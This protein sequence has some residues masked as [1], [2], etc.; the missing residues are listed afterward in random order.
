MT[1]RT[2]AAF[3][4]VFAVLLVPTRAFS[5][6]P[7]SCINY[8]NCTTLPVRSVSEGAVHGSGPGTG[9]YNLPAG[10]LQASGYASGGFGGGAEVDARDRYKVIGIPAGTPLAFNAQLD[11]SGSGAQTGYFYASLL[12]G[13]SNQQSWSNSNPGELMYIVNTSLVLTINRLA[14]EEF[15]MTSTVSAGTG[16]IGSASTSAALH[17]ANLPQGAQIVSC[18]GFVQDFPVPALPASWGSLK[19]QYR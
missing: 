3:A 5:D 12:E 13:T 4:L 11:V 8:S 7:L 1:L 16:Q 17:F 2:L 10:T 15:E 14:G 6:C 18:Q 9:S 19:A